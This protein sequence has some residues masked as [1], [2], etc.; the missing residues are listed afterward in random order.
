M[1]QYAADFLNLVS[2]S[3]EFIAEKVHLRRLT[4]DITYAQILDLEIFFDPVLGSFASQSRLLHPTERSYLGGNQAGIDA[5]DA[6][7]QSFGKAPDTIKVTS[8]EIRGE[9]EFEMCIR[10]RY[11]HAFPW[12]I[13]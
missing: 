1:D 9:P 5:H 7:F 13:R 2:D 8:V 6:I 3:Q 12:L 4:I 11:L 10:D